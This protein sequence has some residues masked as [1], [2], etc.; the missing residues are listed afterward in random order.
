MRRGASSPGSQ[1]RGRSGI[2][3][4]RALAELARMRGERGGV[5]SELGDLKR[6]RG[7]ALQLPLERVVAARIVRAVS[8]TRVAERRQGFFPC[9]GVDL[10]ERGRAVLKSERLRGDAG[11]LVPGVVR[12][13]RDHR[14]EPGCE[15]HRERR[16][17]AAPGACPR[18]ASFSRKSSSRRSR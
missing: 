13:T 8:V 17:G 2:G 9:L 3:A 12:A 18:V 4:I 5:G 16:G 14:D 15:G 7:S 6:D 11:C 10:R 1:R